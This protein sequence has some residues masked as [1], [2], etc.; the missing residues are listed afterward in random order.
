MI[1]SYNNHD[2]ITS[3]N[4][5]EEDVLLEKSLRPER[6]DDFVGQQDTVENLKESLSSG[7]LLIIFLLTLAQI[8]HFAHLT[9]FQYFVDS[10]LLSY[11]Y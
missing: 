1:E 2:Q 5:Y 4:K 3:P 9:L 11:Q 7:F 10:I 8:H 6:F